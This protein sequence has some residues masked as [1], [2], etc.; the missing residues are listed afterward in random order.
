MLFTLIITKTDF[1]FLIVD[2]LFLMAIKNWRKRRKREKEKKREPQ[3]ERREK[4]DRG[5]IFFTW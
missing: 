5:N 1:H 4:I 3:R 2:V